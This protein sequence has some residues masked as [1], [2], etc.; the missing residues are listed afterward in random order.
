MNYPAML[1]RNG[2]LSGDPKDQRT[3][4]SAEDE[5]ASA[6]DGFKRWDSKAAQA[7]GATQADVAAAASFAA[8]DK[9]GDA[10]EA[11]GVLPNKTKGRK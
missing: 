7:P 1:Y 2:V 8:A 11:S 5:L 10:P 3:V 4:A 9:R 6:A